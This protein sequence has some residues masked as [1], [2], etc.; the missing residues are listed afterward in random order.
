[1]YLRRGA[2]HKPRTP[3]QIMA[4]IRSARRGARRRH[5]LVGGS[6]TVEQQPA[7]GSE[8][9]GSRKERLLR[10][11]GTLSKRNFRLFWIGE[12]TS[13]V[14]SAISSV[15][16]PLVGVRVLHADTFAIALLTSAVW[17]PWLWFGLPAGAG[18]DRNRKRALMI[19]CDL[20]SLI[21]L[22]SIAVSEGLGG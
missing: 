15:V 7:V 3:R 21:L 11:A 18:V 9:P 6:V 14:G 22:A 1:M 19:A 4:V 10:I 13:Q 8:G 17:L 12:T 16:I 2:R 20:V 5:Y